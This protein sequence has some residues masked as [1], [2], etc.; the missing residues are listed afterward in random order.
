MHKCFSFDEVQFIYLLLPCI[1]FCNTGIMA[2]TN[3][4]SDGLEVKS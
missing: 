4:E 3:L 2:K 1:M